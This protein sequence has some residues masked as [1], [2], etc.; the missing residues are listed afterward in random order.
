MEDNL[1]E[2]STSAVIY[3]LCKLTALFDR[4]AF[5]WRRHHAASNNTPPHVHELPR[6]QI[7]P[8]TFLSKPRNEP[9][10]FPFLKHFFSLQRNDH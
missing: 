7:T 4:S 3:L 5:K 2:M 8:A 9:K 10:L 1:R 6:W